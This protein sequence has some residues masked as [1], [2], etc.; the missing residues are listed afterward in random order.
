[1]SNF[2]YD[3]PPSEVFDPL[4]AAQ[5]EL[6]Q[7]MNQQP[8]VVSARSA[9]V[10]SVRSA[11]VANAVVDAALNSRK[12]SVRSGGGANGGNGAGSSSPAGASGV[13]SAPPEPQ[14]N[15]PDDLIT[16]SEGTVDAVADLDEKVTPA[17]EAHHEDHIEHSESDSDAQ[18]P[19]QQPQQPVER[20]YEPVPMALRH[21]D[22]SEIPTTIEGDARFAFDGDSTRPRELPTIIAQAIREELVRLGAPEL[23]ASPTSKTQ[24]KTLSTGSLVT[25]LAMSALDIEI[26]GVDENTRRAAEVLRTGQGR[27]AAIEMKVEQVL[28][29]QQRAQKDLD[30][31]TKRALSA[32]KR[33]YE[34]ELMLTWLLVDKTEP[35][36][37][38]NATATSIDLT[39]KTVVDARAKL[40]EK[41]RELSNDESVQRGNLKIVE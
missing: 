33:L 21:R 10:P 26:P 9:R 14:R 19:Q 36:L 35:R 34:L 13:G 20:L 15:E 5:K 11:G 27:V 40:R 41:A 23:G 37:F 12:Q 38:N 16:E 2:E 28:D 22:G 6:R 25:A 8:A 39:N 1:M 31:M 17:G 18:Q 29:N 24:N 30:A 3:E 32:E 4:Y 7:R